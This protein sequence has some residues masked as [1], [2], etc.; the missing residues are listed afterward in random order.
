MA[1]EAVHPGAIYQTRG[2]ENIRVGEHW[3][4]KVFA[5]IKPR[6]TG[7]TNE[8]REKHIQND[9]DAGIQVADLAGNHEIIQFARSEERRVG[10]E[11]CR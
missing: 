8:H 4:K 2:S 10:K 3:P 6:H 9:G 5:K 11:C 1:L 7:E